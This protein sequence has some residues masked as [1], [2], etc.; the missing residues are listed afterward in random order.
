MGIIG[1]LLQARNQ[2]EN[3][4]LRERELEFQNQVKLLEAQRKIRPLLDEAYQRFAEDPKQLSATI[5]DIFKGYSLETRTSVDPD[6]IKALKDPQFGSR[7]LA[8]SS[9]SG[10]T[11]GEILDEGKQPLLRAQ[12]RLAL[13]KHADTTAATNA[14]VAGDQPATPAA[15]AQANATPPPSPT[16]QPL[17]AGLQA[18]GITSPVAPAVPAEVQAPP[19]AIATPGLPKALTPELQT[20]ADS[21]QERITN[22]KKN[23]GIVAAKAP[24]SK[25]LPILNDQLKTLQEHLFQI[26][27]KSAQEQAAAE[28]QVGRTPV[29]LGELQRGQLPIGTR[30]RDLAKPGA[31]APATPKP[32]EREA[33]DVSSVHSAQKE[34]EALFERGSHARRS[35]DLLDVATSAA[36]NA[37]VTGPYVTP[38]KESIYK[39]GNLFG[40]NTKS[41]TALQV[42]TA[43]T[44][45]FAIDLTAMMK[46]QQSDREFM[47]GVDSAVNKGQTQQAFATLAY[48]KK[49]Q[50]V[51]EME[52]ALQ[53][54]AWQAKYGSLAFKD[55]NDRTFAEAW[56]K[57]REEDIERN[58]SFGERAARA[59]N[60]DYKQVLKGNITNRKRSE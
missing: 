34:A 31:P 60:L 57:Y 25:A 47:A 33:A 8:A 51:L 27:A 37:G 41:Q 49:E 20:A 24:D 30:F 35:Y 1:S 32:I 42:M 59:L 5:D 16:E 2:D 40:V 46:G 45:Q 36:R 19:A 28:A 52:Q 7:L 11:L 38:I 17:G 39:I 9:G 50:A 14:A 26:T 21:L 6:V 3:R 44:P 29:P 58:G 55:A 54:R 53:A 10:Q 18:P 12:A 15:R 48:L 13:A 4:A 43:L 56:N 22:L 23:I